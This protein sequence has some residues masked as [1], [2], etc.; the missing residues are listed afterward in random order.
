MISE[1]FTDVVIYMLKE[2]I[3]PLRGKMIVSK[4]NLIFIY[5]LLSAITIFLPNDHFTPLQ[6][7]VWNDYK[8]VHK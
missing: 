7:R 5:S 6:L 4:F 1:W 8:Y 2:P 3:H